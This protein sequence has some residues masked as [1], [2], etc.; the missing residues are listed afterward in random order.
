MLMSPK[1]PT[2][3]VLQGQGM[4]ESIGPEGCCGNIHQVMYMYGVYVYTYYIYIHTYIPTIQYHTIQH[5]TTQ[6]NAMQCNTIHIVPYRTVPSKTIPYHTIP[7]HPIHKYI[8]IYAQRLGF[9]QALQRR[10]FPFPNKCLLMQLHKIP[11]GK[12]TK[13]P[14][15]IKLPPPLNCTFN[16]ED[17][18]RY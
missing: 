3:H 8:Y 12:K 17:Q 7:Y 9:A 1:S 13:V 6:H 2:L 14:G 16:W 15:N 18:Q 5:N 4:F 10:G 11:M